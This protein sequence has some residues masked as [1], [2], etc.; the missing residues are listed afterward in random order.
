MEGAVDHARLTELVAQN[1]FRIRES[2]NLLESGQLKCQF[3]GRDVT[4]EQ[5][6]WHVRS[7]VN[8]E[9]IIEELARSDG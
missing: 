1:A 7:L 9:T 8:L 6:G 5:I 2:L 3:L 4:E